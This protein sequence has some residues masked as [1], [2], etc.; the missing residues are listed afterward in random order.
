MNWSKHGRIYIPRG[1]Y[2]WNK[3]HAQVPTVDIADNKV[4]RIYFGT[5]DELNRTRTSYIE[6][7]AGE[8]ENVLY[9]HD[10]PVLELGKIGTFDDCGAMPSWVVTH[11]GVK[12]LYYIGWTVRNTVPYHNSIG[13]AV[14]V[15]GGKTFEKFAEGP[16]YAPTVSEPYFTGTS[17]VLIDNGIWRNWYLS[18][19]KWEVIDGRPEPFYHIKYAESPDGINWKRE[20][21]VAIDYNSKNEGGIVKASV[22]KENDTYKMWYSYRNARQYRQNSQN[23]YRIGYAESSDGIGWKRMDNGVGIEASA[24]GWDSE[25]M[26]YPHLIRFKGKKYMFYNGNGFGKSGFGYAVSDS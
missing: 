6:V 22:L 25:M 14:S 24:E 7:E 19:T 13:L 16:V 4:W 11:E 18:G 21:V 10:A 23:S 17:C 15:D 2:R 8:P 3:S 1:Q 9:E 12:Y 20:G 5:R 26:A